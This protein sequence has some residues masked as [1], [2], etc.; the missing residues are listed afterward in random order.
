MGLSTKQTPI[1]LVLLVLLSFIGEFFALEDN[2]SLV[3]HIQASPLVPPP[4]SDPFYDEHDIWHL[5]CFL[6][7]LST[8]QSTDRLLGKVTKEEKVACCKEMVRTILHGNNPTETDTLDESSD[9]STEGEKDYT[10]WMEYCGNHLARVPTISVSCENGGAAA[11]AATTTNSRPECSN[12]PR[13]P[14]SIIASTT[15]KA[16]ADYSLVV[17]IPRKLSK[18]NIVSSDKE[19]TANSSPWWRWS[20]PIT[21]NDPN[22]K[23][24]CDINDDECNGTKRTLTAHVHS[25]LSEEGGMHRQLHHVVM[26]ESPTPVVSS[27]SS[28]T[29][30]TS[31]ASLYLFLVLPEDFFMDMDDPIEGGKTQQE[32]AVYNDA[33]IPCSIEYHLVD[34]EVV[35]IEQPAFDSP[36]HVVGIELSFNA[37]LLGVQDNPPAS[38]SVSSPSWLTLRFTTKVHTRYPTPVNT[39]E[40]KNPPWSTTT[41]QKS[42]G[43][44]N[45]RVVG[46]H[47]KWKDKVATDN[48]V[49]FFQEDENAK[50]RFEGEDPGD[51]S[52]AGIDWNIP[53]WLPTTVAAGSQDDYPWVVLGTLLC[54]LVGAAITLRDLSLVSHWDSTERVDS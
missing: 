54:S 18:F 31:S 33:T 14:P 25:E 5:T 7:R 37:T 23:S 2:Q 16:L 36:Q 15:A 30:L 51:S 27:S 4:S 39:F 53:T 19:D 20:T 49:F 35:D 50:R 42:I 45:P 8:K 11:A 24:E 1:T 12:D 32:C 34:G 44:P 13:Q 29:V 43:L 22:G 10:L 40:N 28:S 52:S 6:S 21:T 9:G 41:R 38:M 3:A 46:G 17:R 47:W 26:V 48:T